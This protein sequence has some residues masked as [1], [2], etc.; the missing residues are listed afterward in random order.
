MNIIVCVHVHMKLLVFSSGTSRFPFPTHSAFCLPSSHR[1]TDRVLSPTIHPPSHF[2]QAKYRLPSP[3]AAP[4][5][6][7]VAWANTIKKR[8]NDIRN[9]VT[10]P[11][12]DA[13]APLEEEGDPL[14]ASYARWRA[15][16]DAS[17]DE[18]REYATAMH[19]LATQF[20]SR[21]GGVAAG[22]KRPREEEGEEKTAC[23]GGAAD[24]EFSVTSG[25]YDDRV[26]IVVDAVREFFC[27]DITF[28]PASTDDEPQRMVFSKYPTIL[29]QRLRQLRRDYFQAHQTQ[30][31]AG[32]E[33]QHIASFVSEAPAGGSLR[34][35]VAPLLEAVRSPKADPVAIPLRVLDV[36]SC[37]G[38]Y[39]GHFESLASSSQ[40][41]F[42]I[43]PEH[44]DVDL[45]PYEGS[46]VL[47][48][49][50]LEC[51]FHSPSTDSSLARTILSPRKEG[52]SETR[53][54]SSL[55]IGSFDVVIFCFMLSYLPTREMR[56]R[57]CFNA[58]RALRAGGLFCVVS[59][60]TQGPRS[61]KWVEPWTHC[62]EGLGF[63]LAQ[64]VIKSKV[65][66]LTFQKLLSDT[67]LCSDSAEAHY[68][69]NFVP[70][71]KRFPE[72]L[73]LHEES[74]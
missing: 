11:S 54:L 27:G 1:I 74:L 20:W 37:Y 49:D 55:A 57:S 38:P 29:T 3:M 34:T 43:R 60:R 62:I 19:D 2:S 4:V 44:V 18:L 67:E 65:I 23:E 25:R 28:A 51:Q 30:M 12:V 72:G 39:R 47:Q 7:N 13:A 16:R 10:G 46:G 61:G 8:H 50:W 63:K 9:A 58:L 33:E 35:V 32:D 59:T 66:L 26:Q 24:V 71:L 17:A 21:G 15:H 56:L 22:S 48:C 73:S 40:S 64:K 6:K 14:E 68:R 5:K 53:A 41:S 69:S 42:V 52:A 45:C 70:L 36:G 31:P